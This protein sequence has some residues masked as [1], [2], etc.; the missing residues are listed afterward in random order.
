M[1]IPSDPGSAAWLLD[2]HF[3]S[4]QHIRWNREA[5]LL[6]ASR[7]M[8]RSMALILTHRFS[9]FFGRVSACYSNS[10]SVALKS[11]R[12]MATTANDIQNGRAYRLLF[13]GEE[14]RPCMSVKASSLSRIKTIK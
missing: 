4:R 13:G 3:R 12:E 10:G 2:Y 11:R 8:T 1:R 6:D 14:R 7:L 9:R 5:D